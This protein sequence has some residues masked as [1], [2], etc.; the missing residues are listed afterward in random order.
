MRRKDREVTDIAEIRSILDA[1]KTMTVAMVDSG[2]PYALPLHYGYELEEGKL[3]LYFHSAP[4]GRKMEILKE[5]PSV[6]CTI[7][8]DNGLIGEGNNACV[9][10]CRFASVMGSGRAS[11][12]SDTLEKKQA[13]DILMKHQTGRESFDYPS[14]L[15]KVAVVRL[16][17]DAFTC[18]ANKGE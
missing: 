5:N 7:A 18:K 15:S 12:L 1:A 14:D 8:L 16:T 9:Y 4:V 3:T 2:K 10:G 13:L 6:F 11:V 17:L